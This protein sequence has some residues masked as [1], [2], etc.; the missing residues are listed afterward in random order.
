VIVV[1]QGCVIVLLRCK[2]G[3]QDPPRIPVCDTNLVG[4][5]VHIDVNAGIQKLDRVDLVVPGVDIFQDGNLD[6]LERQRLVNVDNDGEVIHDLAGID[7][8]LVLIL[9]VCPLEQ[10]LIG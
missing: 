1:L 10:L 2:V 5:I 7:V 8:D 4:I 6:I 3:L 9:A